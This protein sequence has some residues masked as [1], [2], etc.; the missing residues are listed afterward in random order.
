MT[1]STQDHFYKNTVLAFTVLIMYLSA[2]LWLMFGAIHK[3]ASSHGKHVAGLALAAIGWFAHG[4]AL[5]ESVFRGPALA[6]SATDTA[7]IIGWA[8]ATIAILVAFRRT[9]FDLISGCLLVAVGIAAAVTND[10]SRDYALSQHGWQL[11]THVLLSV[12]AYSLIAIGAVL[13]IALSLLD[14][15]LRSHRPL[16][17]LSAL[18]SIEAIES[19]MFQALVA[20]FVLLS[21]ALFS[22][23][24]FVENLFSQ[25]LIHK[26][27]LSCV[28][29]LILAVLFFGRWRY[30]W[31]GQKAA[32]WAISGFTL[33]CL[34]YFGAKIVLEV[35]LNRHWG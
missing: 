31:R 23:F 30:G 34:A 5:C 29:W 16:G 24:I 6:L 13:A 14:R 4:Y 17:L 10:S 27:V 33:L 18:P 21:F 22:G 15:R 3:S 26:V 28:A 11:L 7:S 25:H 32:K 12:I 8:I 2:G 9:R 1:S 35:F 19:G 20:G